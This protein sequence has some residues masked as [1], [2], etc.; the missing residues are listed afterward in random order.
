MPADLAP[1]LRVEPFDEG[2]VAQILHLGSYAE[3]RPTI[4]RLHAAVAA[5]GLRPHGR[6]HELYLGD[7]R[8]SRPERLRTLIRQPVVPA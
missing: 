8:R 4:E 2:R 5:A 6:H 7:P 1:G 3:E